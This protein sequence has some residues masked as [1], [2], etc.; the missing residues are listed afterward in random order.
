MDHGDGDHDDGDDD[1]GD[2]GGSGDEI[3]DGVALGDKQDDP[4]TN[5]ADG[6]NYNGGGGGSNEDVMPTLPDERDP[7]PSSSTGGDDD[8]GSGGPDLPL[9]EAPNGE[10][11]MSFYQWLEWWW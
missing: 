2:G 8:G 11:G 7:L 6:S 4:V 5:L 10:P 1:D 3:V 9:E